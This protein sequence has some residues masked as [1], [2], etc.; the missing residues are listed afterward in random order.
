MSISTA[1]QVSADDTVHETSKNESQQRSRRMDERRSRLRLGLLSWVVVAALVV[2]WWVVTAFGFVSPHALAAPLDVARAGV[3]AAVSGELWTAIGA[4]LARVATGSLFGVITGLVL[5]VLAGLSVIGQAVVDRP[6]QMLRIIPFN[7]LVPLFILFLGIGEPMKVIVVAY[8]VAIPLYINTF[9]GIRD[10]DRK[11]VEVATVYRIP[12]VVIAVQVL[13][14]GALPHVLT[15]LRFAL[16]I[17]W[18]ALVTVEVVNAGAGLGYMLSQ[19][20]QFARTEIIL[21][22]VILYG[23]LGA[24]T[25]WIVRLLERALLRWRSAYS[26]S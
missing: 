7:A 19:A 4:S 5:G 3:E 17:A 2:A 13:L 14:R 26:G 15:G 6:V 1:P 16:G 22:V 23:V 20:Q 24:I 18:I 11:L 21:L 10:V 9:A 8:A 12:R 25:D